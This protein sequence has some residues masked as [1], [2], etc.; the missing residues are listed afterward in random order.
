MLPK[1]MSAP[2]LKG[3][4]WLTHYLTTCL[5]AAVELVRAGR[6]QYQKDAVAFAHRMLRRQVPDS[7]REFDLCGHFYT[8][9]TRGPTDRVFAHCGYN[10]KGPES[11]DCGAVFPHYITP[12][13][14][15]CRL[16]PDH[17]H[18]GHW[19]RAIESYAYGFLLPVCSA[20][21][22]Y[23]MP[24]G[25]FEGQGPLWFS[26]LFHG[27]NAAYGYAAALAL[28]LESFFDDRSFRAIAMGNLQWIAGLHA[29]ITKESLAGCERWRD[30]IPAGK[31]VAYSM[32]YGV[33]GRSAGTW[34]GIRGTVCNGFDSDEQFRF[35]APPTTS[36]DGP[37]M[38][39]DED[40]ITHNGAWLAAVSRLKARSKL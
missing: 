38:F 31:A 16:W 18:A 2:L 28:D 39:T 6:E 14:R 8:Y 34:T 5:L 19:M 22:F 20:N 10:H 4:V 24:N 32:I 11:Y 37:F 25:C 3:H 1:G 40:W 36:T 17:P 7:R 27:M 29:G 23:L 9:G 26:S 30:S 21:P 33:G 12:L 15:M 35:N 13:V